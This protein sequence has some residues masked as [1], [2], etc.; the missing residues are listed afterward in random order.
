MVT[1]EKKVQSTSSVQTKKSTKI[2]KTKTT[3]KAKKTVVKTTSKP[4]A[5]VELNL[6]LDVLD[7]LGSVTG[8]IK[9]PQSVFGAKVNKSLLAQAVR[10]YLF[11]QRQGTVS[12]KTRGEVDG[13][14]R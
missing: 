6:T 8:K 3:V 14:T 13:S 4:M 10:V 5:K 11:N 9:L 12:T 1:T 7:T 2:A